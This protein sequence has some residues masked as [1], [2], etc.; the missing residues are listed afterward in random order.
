MFQNTNKSNNPIVVGRAI[1]VT[2]QLLR[3]V[4]VP[5]DGACLFSAFAALNDITQYGHGQ[6]DTVN[7]HANSHMMRQIVS[8]EV[9]HVRAKCEVSQLYYVVMSGIQL[10]NLVLVSIKLSRGMLPVIELYHVI[11]RWAI[12]S[13]VP[14]I[15]KCNRELNS[16]NS[17]DSG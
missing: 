12:S 4:D 9:S 15:F 2:P 11:T 5:S 10:L 8:N 3:V 7:L 6:V 13:L 17:S 16:G 1:P 14:A